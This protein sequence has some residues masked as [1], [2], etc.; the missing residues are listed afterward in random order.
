MTPPIDFAKFEQ[1]KTTANL[2]SPTGVALAIIQATQREE[3]SMVELGRIIKTDPAFAGRLIKAANGAAGYGR[4]AIASVQDA[5]MVLGVPAV[6]TLALGFSLFSNYRS[7]A[8]VGFDYTAFWSSSLI[9]AVA[10]Q[11]LTQRT[12]VAPVDESYC[13]GLLCRIG[14]LALATAYPQRYTEVLQRHAELPGSELVELER[15]ALAITHN[16]LGA[17]MLAD[18]GVPRVFTEP[19][20]H[21]ERM[22]RAPFDA[23]SRD[24][25]LTCSLALAREIACACLAEEAQRARH[26]VR[27]AVLAERLGLDEEEVAALCDHVLREWAEW[28]RLV[29]MVVPPVAPFFGAHAAAPTPPVAAEAPAENVAAS[30]AHTGMRVLVV[31][32]DPQV[33]QSLR[34]ML[35]AAGHQVKEAALAEQAAE[36]M[37]LMHPHLMIVDWNL[38]DG[39]GVKM[40][41]RL[42]QTRVG[43][44]V[45]VLV[46]TNHD[47]EQRLVE[48]FECGVDDFMTKPVNPRVLAARL[49]AGTRVIRLHEEI[50]RDRDEIRHFAA[51]LAVSNRRMQELALSDP[52]TGFPNRRYFLERLQQE[53]AVTSRHPR[54]IA[55]LAVDIDHFKHINDTY[56][57][58]VGDLVLK[59]TAIS[60]K[61]GLRSEDVI[62]RTG[63]DQFLVLCPDTGLAA[64]RAAAER[65]REAV[66][67]TVVHNGVLQLRITVSIGVATRERPMTDAD[68]LIKQADQGV[69]L[70]KKGGRNRVAVFT[71][72]PMEQ[73][74]LR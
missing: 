38:P 22:E 55:C 34:V 18:W 65:A 39:K 46:L 40:V 37:L 30:S 64:A 58:D 27:I 45:Y 32:A 53:W 54:D 63:G 24:A 59:Q 4:R 8:C 35:E 51:E 14:E 16:A 67:Q 44:S 10:M 70:A 28:G 11:A 41:E 71:V 26:L 3:V 68:A 48:A 74:F 25:T 49:R 1:L 23:G 2:P 57:R 69:A 66:E 56:G 72:R 17:A 60:L 73:V 36:L 7:G 33:R 15:Q 42:R 52:L 5:L 50:E 6:R 20:F 13:V 12:R 29:D 19:V 9:C 21:H 61:R 43:R 31:D 62:A 47:D